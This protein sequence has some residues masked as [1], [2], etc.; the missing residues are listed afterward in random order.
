MTTVMQVGVK[1]NWSH[2][3]E[4]RKQSKRYY[5]RMK[6]EDDQKLYSKLQGIL[7]K[8]IAFERL[9]DISHG[10]DTNPNE[11][12]NNTVSWL[13]PKNRVLCGTHSLWN[14]VCICNLPGVNWTG[15]IQS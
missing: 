15:G 14:R 2:G 10:M 3:P 6:N 7:A 8:Y 4:Q 5:R 11:A 13:A 1:E 12:F 9:C